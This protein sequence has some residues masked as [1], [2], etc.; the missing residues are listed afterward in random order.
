MYVC[1]SKTSFVWYASWIVFMM[2]Y[3]RTEWY[4]FTRM[5]RQKLCYIFLYV[6]MCRVSTT[7]SSFSFQYI[8]AD[9]VVVVAC[10]IIFVVFTTDS[11]VFRSYFIFQTWLE[12]KMFQFRFCNQYKCNSLE[13]LI[14]KTR[15]VIIFCDLFDFQFKS[16]FLRSSFHTSRDINW[17]IL[18]IIAHSKKRFECLKFSWSQHVAGES[19][20]FE[21]CS[22]KT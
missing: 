2:Y 14:Q 13:V 18:I 22:S 15:Q 9:V 16:N 1:A 7:R 8:V 5:W 21:M 19:S 4:T 3:S 12:S 17:K 6:F 10:N 20:K 11:N